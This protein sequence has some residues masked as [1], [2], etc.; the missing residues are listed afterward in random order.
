[1]RG[2]W[3][4]FGY[5]YLLM[6]GM[7]DLK[8]RVSS[9]SVIFVMSKRKVGGAI[10]GS[11]DD[12]RKRRYAALLSMLLNQEGLQDIQLK[13]KKHHVILPDGSS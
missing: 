1:M 12:Y 6:D 10:W 2:F 5:P 8:D 11:R 3:V 4:N 9:D 13:C 7:W